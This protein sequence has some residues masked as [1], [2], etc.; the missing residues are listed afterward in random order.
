MS[1]EHKQGLAGQRCIDLISVLIAITMTH[2][3]NDAYAGYNSVEVQ[4]RYESRGHMLEDCKS[5]GLLLPEATAVPVVKNMQV[6]LVLNLTFALIEFIGGVMTNS[7]AI[8]SDAVHDLG[9]SVAIGM[10][11]VLE[12]HS[13][14]GRSKNFSYGKR[15]FSI[16]AALITSLILIAGS[17]IIV[18]RAVPRFFAPEP[19]HVN[20]VL[21]L[22]V[23]G[24]VFNGAAAL[25]LK[26]GSDTSLNQRAIMLHLVEDVL[27]WAA[28][29]IGAVLMYFTHWYWIDPLLSLGLAAF[30]SYNATKNMISAFKILLQAKPEAVNEADLI[31]ALNNITHVIDVHDLHIWTMDGTYTVFTAHL[32]VAEESGAIMAAVRQ[33]ALQLLSGFGIQH[34]TLQIEPEYDQCSSRTYNVEM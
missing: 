21:G 14:K 10:A 34:T 20:G 6:A 8:L 1:A 2:Y 12:K 18:C 32:V 33:T 7:V 16:L 5:S 17:V 24:L 27:G 26:K 15:R 9:D 22:A 4:E 31:H 3:R 13:R 30:I 28:V 25:R 23:L 11:L 29:L 19:V